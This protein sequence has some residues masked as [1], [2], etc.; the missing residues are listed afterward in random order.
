MR[1]DSLRCRRNALRYLHNALRAGPCLALLLALT[2]T[3]GSATEP[4]VHAEQA[5]LLTGKPRIG[6]IFFSPAERRNRH[7]S[8]L[9]ATPVT[10][11]P[12]N[13]ASS[14]ERLVVNGALSSLTQG[15]AVWINGAAVDNS[16]VN[17]TAW[18][19]RNGN[20]WLNNGAQ[21]I[22]LIRPGQSIDR[23]GAIED[24]LPAGSVTRH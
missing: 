10:P 6:R 24:L 21:G 17:K 5:A 20:V 23:S 18:T 22:H 12:V 2:P 19:D 15:R 1:S 9:D 8:R 16:S 7:A 4:T 13:R 11:P 3:L 14:G